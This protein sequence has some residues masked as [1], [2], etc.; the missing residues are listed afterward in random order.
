MDKYTKNTLAVTKEVIKKEDLKHGIPLWF[1][2]ILKIKNWIKKIGQYI[3]LYPFLFQMIFKFI[4]FSMILN[5]I[6]K[7]F[8]IR[9]LKKS[10][11]GLKPFNCNTP[12]EDLEL[13]KYK[14]LIQFIH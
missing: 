6:D 1:I 12:D 3:T 9:Y 11:L 4:D 10:I 8:K 2:H 14:F 5:W 7:Q 13:G